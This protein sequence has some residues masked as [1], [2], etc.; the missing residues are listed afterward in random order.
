MELRRKQMTAVIIIGLVI[1]IV[2]AARWTSELSK[3]K[4]GGFGNPPKIAAEKR[5]M[6]NTTYGI[7]FSIVLAGTSALAY[8]LRPK[9]EDKDK[10]LGTEEKPQDKEKQ[11]SDEEKQKLQAEIAGLKAKLKEL[12]E[13]TKD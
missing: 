6:T 10:S 12:D 3:V 8:M 5:I 7:W 11:K 1:L 13:K 4:V 2:I 9:Q